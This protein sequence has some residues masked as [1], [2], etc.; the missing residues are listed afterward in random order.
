MSIIESL[1]PWIFY[2]TFY[3][4][5][6]W[7]IEVLSILIQERKWTN[8]GFLTG[9]FVILFGFG[10][11]F[12]IFLS[13]FAA[14]DALTMFLSGVFFLSLLE[15]CTSF[16]MEKIFGARWWDYGKRKFNLNGRVALLPSLMWG[17]LSVFLVFFIHPPIEKISVAVAA[18]SY[19]GIIAA[20]ISAYFIADFTVSFN[21]SSKLKDN[22]SSVVEELKNRGSVVSLIGKTKSEKSLMIRKIFKKLPLLQRK[23]VSAYPSFAEDM[24]AKIISKNNRN[25]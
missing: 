13:E 17:V 19:G 15:Y 21:L 24:I 10:A 16:F 6:G 4:F 23:I 14:R 20:I 22:I 7:V 18:G 8:R 11:C 1:L 3:S 2:F 9:P 12:I 25:S 5:L